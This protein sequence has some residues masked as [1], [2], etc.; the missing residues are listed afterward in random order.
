MR[1]R[2]IVDK[3]SRYMAEVL[4]A[5]VAA[6]PGRSYLS[7]EGSHVHFHFSH[8]ERPEAHYILVGTEPQGKGAGASLAIPIQFF[9][10]PLEHAEVS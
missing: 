6:L 1:M 3:L 8:L 5:K 10:S 4:Q 2:E 9:L 7:T